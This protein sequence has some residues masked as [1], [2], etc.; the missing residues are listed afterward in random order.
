R[1]LLIDLGELQDH[2]AGDA[3]AVRL[4]RDLRTDVHDERLLLAVDEAA[5]LLDAD[6]R[7]PKGDVEAPSLPPLDPDEETERDTHQN[8]RAPAQ[9]IQQADDALDRAVEDE[10]EGH[11]APG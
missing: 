1:E 11:R 4:S 8:E 9:C 3:A 10:A 7:H 5:Q 2:R 6:A